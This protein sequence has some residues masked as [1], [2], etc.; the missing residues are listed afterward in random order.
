MSRFYTV[1][2]VISRAPRV[3]NLQPAYTARFQPSDKPATT[4]VELCVSPCS[5]LSLSLVF[6]ATTPIA[7]IICGCERCTYDQV[8]ENRLHDVSRRFSRL[9]VRRANIFKHEVLKKGR[10]VQFLIVACSPVLSY[11]ILSYLVRFSYYVFGTQSRTVN[12]YVGER[13]GARS[14]TQS[15]PVLPFPR[16]ENLSRNN[17]RIFPI[18]IPSPVIYNSIAHVTRTCRTIRE[19]WP[20]AI[21]SACDYI[22][23]V[24]QQPLPGSI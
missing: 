21:I 11:L 8:R 23:F 4:F 17:E 16:G 10:I 12:R 15:C 7:V 3:L 22:L 14:I 13:S 6:Q 24:Q 1:A 2:N 19:S 5:T 18:E 9:R 20:P